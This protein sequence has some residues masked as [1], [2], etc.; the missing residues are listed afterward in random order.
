MPATAVAPIPAGRGW[1]HDVAIREA[2][3]GKVAE[4]RD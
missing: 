4:P 3:S 1:Y 2:R